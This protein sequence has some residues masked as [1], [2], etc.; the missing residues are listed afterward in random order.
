MAFF[1]GGLSRTFNP[2][3]R[4]VPTSSCASGESTLA[5]VSTVSVR[6]PGDKIDEPEYV[7]TATSLPS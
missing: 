3:H 7:L 5:I 2:I 1:F 6:L 4:I